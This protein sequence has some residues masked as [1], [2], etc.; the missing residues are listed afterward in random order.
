MQLLRAVARHGRRS[1][2]RPALAVKRTGAFDRHGMPFENGPANNLDIAY[3]VLD[4]IYVNFAEKRLPRE[5]ALT[6]EDRQ[7]LEKAQILQT[8]SPAY[9]QTS[10]A[11][12][13]ARC[14]ITP[15]IAIPEDSSF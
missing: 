5:Q 8:N 15:G 1:S 9:Q 2:G 4:E 6:A 7:L 11:A 13:R 3:K 12:T 14:S 10:K